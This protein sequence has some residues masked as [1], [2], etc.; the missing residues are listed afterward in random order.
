MVH[1][2]VV[3]TVSV[4]LPSRW[5]RGPVWIGDLTVMLEARLAVLVIGPFMSGHSCA[6]GVVAG[7]NLLRV[8]VCCEFKDSL[9]RA[10]WKDIIHNLEALWLNYDS[11]KHP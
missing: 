1:L 5:V 2:A 8:R 11:G 4:P 10:L 6:L 3:G 9:A 7:S